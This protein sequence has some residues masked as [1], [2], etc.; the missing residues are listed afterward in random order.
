MPVIKQKAQLNDNLSLSFYF[1]NNGIPLYPNCR[2]GFDCLNDEYLNAFPKRT[3]IAL[4]VHGFVRLKEQQL[5][6]RLWMNQI[7]NK[8]ET[9]GFV[10]VGHLPKDIVETYEKVVKFSFFD[11]FIEERRNKETKSH[12]N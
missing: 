5:E 1:A 4:G 10:V 6:W 8:S 3:Y 9:V 11:S 2:G 12:V 7:V